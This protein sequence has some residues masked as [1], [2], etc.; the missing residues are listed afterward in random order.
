MG[1]PENPLRHL[2]WDV[3]E[4]PWKGFVEGTL[5]E[6][7]VHEIELSRRDDWGI[8]VKLK[9]YIADKVSMEQRE[10]QI[11]IAVN[12]KI[13]AGRIAR[14]IGRIEASDELNRSKITITP[15]IES[16]SSDFATRVITFEAFA[17]YLDL[18]MI[19]AKV[20]VSNKVVLWGLNMRGND[21]LMPRSTKRKYVLTAKREM[22]G[23]H[24]CIEHTS[25]KTVGGQDW[26]QLPCSFSDSGLAALSL[27]DRQSAE[28]ASDY[29]PFRVEI[30]INSGVD[31]PSPENYAKYFATLSMAF[32]RKL[33]MIGYTEYDKNGVKT[34]A[35]YLAPYLLTKRIFKRQSMPIAQIHNNGRYD[36]VAIAELV[37]KIYAMT[38]EHEL[39]STVLDFIDSD[40]LPLGADLRSMAA[41][42]DT[43]VKVY[44][45]NNKIRSTYIPKKVWSDFVD[46]MLPLVVERL[47][48]A[49]VKQIGQRLRENVNTISQN[50]LVEQV[51]A[52]MELPIEAAE[53]AALRE[54]GKA[55]HNSDAASADPL[56]FIEKRNAYRVICGRVFLRL[57]GVERP[58][59]DYAHAWRPKPLE[60]PAGRP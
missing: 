8:A 2:E 28:Q 49:N 31:A 43:L 4:A 51:L 15:V 55:V 13:A 18:K 30:N 59:V 45:K 22:L 12:G 40:G 46:E 60:R 57:A 42:L 41:V 19:D 39:H 35:R 1:M 37:D 7:G 5:A 24:D 16:I 10:E 14:P 25:S 56:G 44:V 32:G 11:L 33:L 21:G 6:L 29:G 38:I 9:A 27:V 58:Y 36:E 47:G 54:R 17:W 48:S 3:L 52:S 20:P 53:K 34:R 23:G 26:I 50:V